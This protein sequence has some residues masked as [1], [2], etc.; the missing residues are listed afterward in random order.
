M[1]EQTGF[2]RWPEIE[3]ALRDGPLKTTDVAVVTGM[4]IGPVSRYLSKLNDAGKITVRYKTVKDRQIAFW[5][6]K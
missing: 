5:E 1:N 3:A 2:H 6:L 4:G